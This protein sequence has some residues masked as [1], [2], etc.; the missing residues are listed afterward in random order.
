MEINLLKMGFT[1]CVVCHGFDDWFPVNFDHDNTAFK[2][3]GEH[4][5]LECNACHK[6]MLVNGETQVQYKFE[7]FEC[8][9]CH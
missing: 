7:S 3:D 1:N 6:E 4:E 5:K 9:D 8:I 2:L